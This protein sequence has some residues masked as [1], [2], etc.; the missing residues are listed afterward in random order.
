MS[1]VARAFYLVA[2]RGIPFCEYLI[3]SGNA[4]PLK[5]FILEML[6]VCGAEMPPLFGDIPYTGTNIPIDILDIEAIRR[7][8][9]FEIHIPFNEGV[10]MTMDW[11]NTIRRST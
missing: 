7:D 4:R 6:S 11:L 9:G 5:E 10:R 2:E 8:C 3:G 1:D